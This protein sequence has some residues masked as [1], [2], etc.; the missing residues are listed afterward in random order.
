MMWLESL[1]P[2]RR[3]TA[4]SKRSPSWEI[5]DRNAAK[6]SKGPVFPAPAAENT[7]ATAKLPEKPPMA[8]AQVFFGLTFGQSFG[9]PMPRPAKYPPISAA[10]TTRRMK[11]NAAEPFWGS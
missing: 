5:T 6:A 3:F 11:N 9:P 4:D 1:T 7:A 10:Q 8:P 2:K